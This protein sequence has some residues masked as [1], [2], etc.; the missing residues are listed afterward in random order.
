MRA[1]GLRFQGLGLGRGEGVRFRLGQCE[2]EQG[3]NP[4]TPLLTWSL[5]DAHGIGVGGT[6]AIDSFNL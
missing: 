5:G 6:W 1:K 4:L 2:R 3:Q